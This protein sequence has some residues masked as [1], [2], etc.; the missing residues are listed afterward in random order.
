MMEK[1]EFRVQGPEK[2]EQGRDGGYNSNQHGVQAP[3]KVRESR[4]MKKPAPQNGKDKQG[5]FKQATGRK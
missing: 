5:Q 2:E 3:M 4:S 1:L